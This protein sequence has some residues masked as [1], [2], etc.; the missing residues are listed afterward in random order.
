MQ[1]QKKVGVV[2][3]GFG[4]AGKIHF[5]GIRKNHLCS[6]RYIVDQVENEAIKTAIE[7]KLDEYLLEGVKVVG[8]QAFENVRVAV[9][10][11]LPL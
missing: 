8:I 5:E 3:C 4:R 9:V 11:I 2:I 1:N 6:L 7:K 10:L